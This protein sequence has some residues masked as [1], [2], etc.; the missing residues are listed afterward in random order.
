MPIAAQSR[1]T[2]EISSSEL[3]EAAIWRWTNGMTDA[4]QPDLV[5]GLIKVGDAAGRSADEDAEIVPNVAELTPSCTTR[6]NALA[7]ET[8]TRFWVRGAD[9]DRE[10]RVIC[11]LSCRLSKGSRSPRCGIFAAGA[12]ST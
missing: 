8:T 10:L 9:T 4:Q 3:N 7:D 5:V 2:S 11:T 1:A 12:A 6:G